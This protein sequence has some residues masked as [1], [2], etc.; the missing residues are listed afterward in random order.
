M[1]IVNFLCS[2][3]PNVITIVQRVCPLLR[4]MRGV[5]PKHHIVHRL[6][7]TCNKMLKMSNIPKYNKNTFTIG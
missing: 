7:G 3:N 2:F 5:K 4:Y 1:Y 6:T